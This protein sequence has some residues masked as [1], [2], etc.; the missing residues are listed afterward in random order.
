MFNITGE[1]WQNPEFNEVKYLKQKINDMRSTSQSVVIDNAK[2]RTFNLSKKLTENKQRNEHEIVEHLLNIASMQRRM[3][4][5]GD[6]SF[7]SS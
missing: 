5:Q 2:P 7:E 3:A 4:N 1:L 6:V